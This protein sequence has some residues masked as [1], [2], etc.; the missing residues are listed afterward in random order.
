VLIMKAFSLLLLVISMCLVLANC[1]SRSVPALRPPAS[2]D[3]LEEL[4]PVAAGPDDMVPGMVGSAGPQSGWKSWFGRGEAAESEATYTQ[5]RVFYGTDR[6]HWMEDGRARYGRDF[7]PF[8]YGVTTVSIPREHKL[9]KLESPSWLKLEFRED[10]N[11]HVM[12]MGAERKS[13]DDFFNELKAMTAESRRE[14]VLLFVHGFNVAFDDAARRTAQ[15]AYD[16]TFDG[17]PVFY[18]WPSQSRLSVSGYKTD[19]EH[20]EKAMPHL[21]EFL[22][23]VATRSGAKRIY[24]IA[25]SMGNRVL[26]QAVKELFEDKKCALARCCESIVL[27]APDISAKVFLQDIAPRLVESDARITL[28]ASSA[29]L[30]LKGSQKFNGEPR[31]G[32]I[33]PSPVIIDGMETVDASGVDTSLLGHSY[34]GD[35]TTVVSDLYQLIKYGRR[36]WLRPALKRV[37]MPAGTLYRFQK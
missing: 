17:A 31:A 6:N 36:A 7:G 14:S 21:K 19:A 10:P 37:K 20:A 3:A 12:V 18:S 32:D 28:Y 24:L 35:S 25:H 26:T 4:P 2:T 27:A 29:D 1:A 9:A 23:D 5:M 34:Y 13:K 16:L 15:L 33:T 8:D 30:A 22:N 11:K